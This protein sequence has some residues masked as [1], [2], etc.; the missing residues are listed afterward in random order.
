[1]RQRP[2]RPGA[3]LSEAIRQDIEIVVAHEILVDDLDL[4]KAEPDEAIAHGVLQGLALAVVLDLM[5]R[6][7][8]DVEH[9]FAGSVLRADLLSAH[10]RLRL[11]RPAARICWY[12]RRAGG[13]AG[14]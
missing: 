10:R 13:P 2:I 1:V 4:G 6:G 12:G 3:F 5:G 11:G 9:G 8:A 7:L 14:G